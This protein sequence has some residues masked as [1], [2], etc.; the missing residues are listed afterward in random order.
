[1][2]KS[3]APTRIAIKVDTISTTNEPATSHHGSASRSMLARN[4]MTGPA[5]NGSQVI[6]RD[7]MPCGSRRSDRHHHHRQ[8]RRQRPHH[9]QLLR[10]THVRTERPGAEHEAAE[11]QERDEEE[12]DGQ[13]QRQPRH[14]H[15]RRT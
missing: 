15:L 10:F 7:T 14:L 9:R 1:M 5:E 12:R 11:E 3:V 13:R 6:T 8:R 4:M 2:R